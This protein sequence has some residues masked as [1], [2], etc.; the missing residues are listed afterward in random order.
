MSSW[1]SLLLQKY[2]RVGIGLLEDGSQSAFRHVA[3]VVGN[4]GVPVGCRVEPDF[5]AACGLAVKFEAELFL[6]LDDLPIAEARK[7]PH[8]NA[9][10]KG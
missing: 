1:L 7:P 9:T 2:F 10:I 8:Q 3:G 5:V 6:T 4:G